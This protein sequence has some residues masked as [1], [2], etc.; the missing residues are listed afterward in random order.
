M[1]YTIITINDD[2]I[3]FKKKIIEH[4]PFEQLK[5]P[6]FNAYEHD[7]LTGLAERG[8]TL[9]PVWNNAKKGEIGVWISN[10][11]TWRFAACMEEPLIVFE[12]DAIV[13]QDFS[14][15]FDSL[16]SQLPK[17]WD[18]VALWVPENQRMD[19]FYD[20]QYNE[21]GHPRINGVFK[22]GRS[23]FSIDGA[24]KTAIVYQGYGMVSLMYSPAGA[25]KLV[26]L[27]KSEGITTPVDCW[28]YEQAHKGNLNGYAPRPEFADIVTY[29]WSAASH[30]QQTERAL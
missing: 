2:R 1:K 23:L 21:N 18:F 25:K 30:V 29:D 11:D 27:T 10:Y 20:V 22:D 17:N 4:V 13:G 26:R 7:P 12:D 19:Y 3:V 16:Y 14:W 8:L 6:A 5:L 28:I 24:D 9:D 15:R